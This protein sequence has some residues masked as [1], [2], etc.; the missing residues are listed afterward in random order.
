VPG[1]PVKI[2]QMDWGEI[3]KKVKVAKEREDRRGKVAKEHN[4]T[5]P[6]ANIATGHGKIRKPDPVVYVQILALHY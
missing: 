3:S 2:K 5:Q 4:A 1:V 6:R